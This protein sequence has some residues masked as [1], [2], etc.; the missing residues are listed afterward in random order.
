[1]KPNFSDLIKP[2]QE[3]LWWDWRGVPRYAKW[4]PGIG[5]DE[6]PATEHA[7]LLI[8]CQGC[9]TPFVVDAVSLSKEDGLADLIRERRLHYGDPP[10]KPCCS[11]G[12]SM[13]SVPIRVLQYW[14]CEYTPSGIRWVR[15]ASLEV[16]ITLEWA[17]ELE[18]PHDD[19]ECRRLVANALHGPSR[20]V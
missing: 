6:L 16:D 7:L 14:H 19:E 4:E 17:I 18:F 9:G 3:P 11:V 5:L 1:M 20:P 10:F 12:Y 15:D 8:R 13:N 2:D